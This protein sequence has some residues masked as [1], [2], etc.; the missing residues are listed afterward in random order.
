MAVLVYTCIPGCKLHGFTNENL[1][2]RALYA[3]VSNHSLS[4]AV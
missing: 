4:T 2:F 3:S 1:N